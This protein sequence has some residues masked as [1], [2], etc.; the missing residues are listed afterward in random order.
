MCRRKGVGHNCDSQMACASSISSWGPV[1]GGA[2]GNPL[3]LSSHGL[4]GEGQR[5]GPSLYPGGGWSAPLGM[6]MGSVGSWMTVIYHWFLPSWPAP[7]PSLKFTT[8]SSQQTLSGFSRF[9]WGPWALSQGGPPWV[10]LP[11]PGRAVVHPHSQ[12][13]PRIPGSD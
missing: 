12:L 9:L 11:T 4:K 3:D 1:P 7:P 2:D 5:V 10:L 8:P 6:R 13:L